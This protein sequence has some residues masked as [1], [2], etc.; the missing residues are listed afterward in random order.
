MNR[1]TFHCWISNLHYLRIIVLSGL[2]V[3]VHVIE[4]KVR[5]FK[6]GRGQ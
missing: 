3:V 1:V 5:G 6:P 4:L 2:V